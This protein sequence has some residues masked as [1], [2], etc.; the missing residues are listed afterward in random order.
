MN[1]P[2]VPTLDNF[3]AVYQQHQEHTAYHNSNH[4]SSVNNKNEGDRNGLEEAHT[5]ATNGHTTLPEAASAAPEPEPHSHNNHTKIR[6]TDHDVLCGRG[7]GT[8]AQ[9]GNKR[10]RALCYA[11]KREF[12]AGNHAAKRRIGAEI[13]ATTVQHWGGRFLT[14]SSHTD[15]TLAPM[16]VELDADAA[17]KKAQQVMRDCQRPDRV[18]RDGPGRNKRNRSTATP[19]LAELLLMDDGA[20]SGLLPVPVA[21]AAAPLQP[22]LDV[23]DGV[24]AHDVLLGRGAF[25]NGHIGNERYVH[26]E[27]VW[28]IHAPVFIRMRTM[29]ALSHCILPIALC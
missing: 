4:S 14:R 17:Q 23:P 15:G 12:D 3:T 1:H 19:E 22:I 8:N 24:H 18:E 26:V 16:W 28:C 5:E 11:R 2:G 25:V 20:T 13:V 6:P 9:M 27:G 10:F 7:Y 21:A 29:Q